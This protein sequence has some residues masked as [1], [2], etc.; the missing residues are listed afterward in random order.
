MDSVSQIAL[1][2]AVGEACLGKKIGN[3]AMFY[4][5]IAGTIPD[6][7]VFIGKYYSAVRAL[8]LHRGF[9]HSFIFCI[10]AAPILG[11]LL[12]KLYWRKFGQVSFFDWTMMFFMGL[13]THPVLDC[14]TTWG[15]QIFWP[16]ETRVAFKSI[17][18]I[19]PVYTVPLLLCL[20]FAM[21]KPKE[22]R[23]RAR[24]NWFG[25]GFSCSYL[26]LTLVLHAQGFNGVKESLNKQG[27]SYKRLE[28]RPTPFN[29]LLWA[30]TVER[31]EDYLIGYYSLLRPNEK[32]NFISYP[33]N[34][35]LLKDY[36]S[37]DELLR[38]TKITKN[39]YTVIDGGDYLQLND[40]RFGNRSINKKDDRF[41]FSY[42]VPKV[43]DKS[44]MIT[45]IKTKPN[46]EEA[47]VYLKDLWNHLVP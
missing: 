37:H 36:L 11:V 17:F 40:L 24:Y 25:L 39:Y 46:K 31:D 23:K 3:R 33:K 35:H 7:D 44:F 1:G 45:E 41:I 30:S 38:L 8:E 18:V 26:M 6:L 13:A 16:M 2:A 14:F 32:V 43:A 29:S 22:S 5:A 19:D 10:I 15:T 42:K 4:G 34:W 9:S 12:R 21:R 47:R 20:V 27:I 28:V